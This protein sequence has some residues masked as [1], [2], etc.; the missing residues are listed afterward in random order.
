MSLVGCCQEVIVALR[1]TVCVFLVTAGLAWIAP[2]CDSATLVPS[3]VKQSVEMLGVPSARSKPARKPLPKKGNAVQGFQ[4]VAAAPPFDVAKS[5]YV[6]GHG[7]TARLK[8]VLVLTET[9]GHSAGKNVRTH[10]IAP[11]GTWIL[12]NYSVNSEGKE[13]PK[14]YRVLARGSLTADQLHR[15]GKLL[16]EYRLSELPPQF[17]HAPEVTPYGYTLRFGDKE[18]RVNGVPPHRHGKKG[19]SMEEHIRSYAL[20]EQDPEVWKRFAIIADAVA[21]P[22]SLRDR[23]PLETKP[24]TGR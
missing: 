8:Q 6:T 15:L 16:D 1:S 12:V 4:Y 22:E 20:D 9:Q 21:R 19:L 11:D 5:P 13:F 2:A 3:N 10:T 24:R 17:G 14:T 23:V 18:S 7:E